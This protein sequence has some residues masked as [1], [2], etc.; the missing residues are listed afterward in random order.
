MSRY[1]P[2]IVQLAVWRLL[3]S[4]LLMIFPACAWSDDLRLFT[5]E[6]IV[7]EHAGAADSHAEIWPEPV[8]ISS[9]HPTI[10]LRALADPTLPRPTL[11]EAA[12]FESVPSDQYQLKAEAAALGRSSR[13]HVLLHTAWRQ[14]GTSPE[15][16]I[17]IELD[18]PLGDSPGRSTAHTDNR[19]ATAS[20]SLDS[21]TVDTASGLEPTRPQK[22]AR[23]LEGFMR[24]HLSRYLHLAVDL[25]YY[26]GD[27]ATSE[28]QFLSE[29]LTAEV[30]PL[31]FHL[32]ESRRLRSGELHYFDH[33]VLGVVATVT[34][35]EPAPAPEPTAQ[36]APSPPPA[37]SGTRAGAAER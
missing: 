19:L 33:P 2:S 5:V 35:Y 4:A 30:V 3:A 21:Q 24:L 10:S 31:A 27:M 8:A 37:A 20:P 16:A 14:P 22:P 34:P 9:T 12:L 13:Y 7:F 36:P 6:V 18:Y 1:Y 26:N 17:A 11:P 28:S 23:R 15:G 32:E 29:M 25:S